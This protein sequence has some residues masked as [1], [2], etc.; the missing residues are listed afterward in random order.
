MSLVKKSSEEGTD[1][2]P[3]G[4][5]SSEQAVECV[6]V[7]VNGVLRVWVFKISLGIC[8]ANCSYYIGTIS[9]IILPEGLFRCNQLA[10]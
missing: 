10:R 1:P 4:D 8:T 3:G 2:D 6:C 5:D 7:W 9:Q